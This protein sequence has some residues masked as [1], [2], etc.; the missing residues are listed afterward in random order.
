MTQEIRTELMPGVRFRAIHT[1]KFKSAYLSVSFMAPLKEETAAENALIPHVLRRG[2]QAHPDMERISA[3][4]DDLYGGAIEPAV[5]KKGETQCVGFAASFLDDAY[6]L[7]G[8]EI[9]EPAA[10]LLGEL[11]VAAVAYDS[12]TA[13]YEAA[14]NAAAKDGVPLLCLG[15]LYTYASL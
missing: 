8:E 13:A 1:T 3:A 2:T 5:R 7:E 4:L 6:A 9:L 15:S 11:G 12:V 10:A 14:R